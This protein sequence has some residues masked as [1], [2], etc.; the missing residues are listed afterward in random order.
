MLAG[1][2]TGA[3]A[4]VLLV[5]ADRVPGIDPSL[6]GCPVEPVDPKLLAAVSALGHPPRVIGIFDQPPPRDL[7]VAL[8]E[9][10]RGG[11][12]GPWI[13]LDGLGDPGN[14]G[15]V[16]RSAAALGAGGVV[17]L[18]RT[19]DPFGPK[20][21]R[22]SMGACFRTPVVRLDGADVDV[23]LELEA[24]RAAS[25]SLRVVVL[26]AAG[27]RP[28]TDV[29][30]DPTTIVVVGSEREGASPSLLAAAD[31]VVSIPQDPRVESINA[32]VAASIA[33]YEWRRGSAP[34]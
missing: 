22:A 12:T 26:D 14:V 24:V 3:S 20:A 2:E 15:T 21:A 10:A 32:A 11:D 34:T 19:A 7:A 30:L 17:T 4:R 8:D 5:D 16:L 9:R 25:P 18:P 6:A 23:A 28:L 31:I 13:A 1:L 27:E 29:P 33:L